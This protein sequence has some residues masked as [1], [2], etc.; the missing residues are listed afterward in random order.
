MRTTGIRTDIGAYFQRLKANIAK[1]NSLFPNGYVG[2]VVKPSFIGGNTIVSAFEQY[3]NP[4]KG[5]FV[6][7]GYAPSYI[8]LLSKNI[9]N[10][11]T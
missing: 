1:C 8:G 7:I 11:N 5:L 6:L 10:I 2:E 4:Y 3:G 9:V